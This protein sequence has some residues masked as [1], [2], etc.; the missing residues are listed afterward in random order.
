MNL[1]PIPASLVSS[2]MKTLRHAWPHWELRGGGRERWGR[3]GWTDGWTNGWTDDEWERKSRAVV[4][5]RVEPGDPSCFSGYVGMK[6]H[7]SFLHFS[8]VGPCLLPS[9]PPASVSDPGPEA[10]PDSLADPSRQ[11]APP[12]A[13]AAWGVAAS[14]GVHGWSSVLPGRLR[15][16]ARLCGVFPG[17]VAAGAAGPPSPASVAARGP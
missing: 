5:G 13:G 7:M 10:G 8:S 2:H 16:G 1:D 4:S 17:S 14:L 3:R 9:S 15:P 11:A 12:C 6:G